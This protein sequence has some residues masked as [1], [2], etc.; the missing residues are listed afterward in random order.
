MA[1][2]A[3]EWRTYRDEDAGTVGIAV[4]VDDGLT[5]AMWLW[6]RDPLQ[7]FAPVADLGELLSPVHR[8]GK[9]QRRASGPRVV[10]I[11][12]GRFDRRWAAFDDAD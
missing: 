5:G 9:S 11:A 12:G 3:V 1:G 4:R 8:V 10:P 6:G 7:R 2:Y